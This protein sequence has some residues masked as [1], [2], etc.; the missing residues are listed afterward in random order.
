[1]EKEEFIDLHFPVAGI[2]LSAPF[3]RQPNRD[4]GKGVYGRT[5][6][7]AV[8]VRGFEASAERRRGGTRAG[9]SKYIPTPVV[10]D[11]L[12]QSLAVIVWTS[13]TAQS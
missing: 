11:W 6:V 7:S 1:M 2:N 12:V 13:S 9:L 3:W 10:A 5:C 8:N 4:V